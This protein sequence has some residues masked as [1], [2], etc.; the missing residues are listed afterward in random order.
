MS[1]ISRRW[2]N[3][4]LWLGLGALL[5]PIG[6]NCHSRTD[7][8]PAVSQ[9]AEVDSAD[10]TVR[11]MASVEVD[12]APQG[13]SK[14][15]LTPSLNGGSILTAKQA[16]Q[17]GHVLKLSSADDAVIVKGTS[18]LALYDNECRMKVQGHGPSPAGL[19]FE[20]EALVPSNDVAL[21]A[22]T[23]QAEADPCLVRVDENRTLQLIAPVTATDAAAFQA[24]SNQVTAQATVNDP[25]IAEARHIGFSKALESWDWFFS[26]TGITNDVIVAVIDTGIFY[27]HPDLVDNVYT[28]AAG[29]HGYDFVNSD[30]DPL[31]DAGHGT[32]CSGIIGARANNGIGVSGVM[33]MRVKVM[34]VK[35]LSAQGSGSEADI[36]N[37]VR[38]AADQGAQVINLSLGGKFVSPTIRDALVY[39][40]GKGVVLAIAAGNDGVLM[41]AGAN[42]YAPS[43]YA[44]DIPGA[45]A[46]GSVDSINGARS[47]FSNYSTSYVFIGAPGSAAGSNG[48]LSTYL[49]NGY[50][51][52]QG[53]SM[54]SPVVAGAAALLVGA[55]KSHGIAYVPADVVNLLTDSARTN[56]TLTTFFRGGA[57]LDVQR[58]A[59]LFYSRYVMAGNG[60]TEVQ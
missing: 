29:K 56:A 26:G 55:F 19:K 41:D 45:I 14:V 54:A 3:V 50:T 15:R 4:S 16:A 10:Q 49:A 34:G 7:Q 40:A 43:G 44:K 52:L 38:Y 59:Q 13:D 48:V 20:A 5:S 2:R 6:F 8:S 30:D 1:L 46:V 31:D 39:A 22:L 57:T 58:A 25:R 27:T 36:V 42:F 32:H 21:S 28:N 23:A 37:G 35:V 12:G 47:G 18:L 60:G 11:A 51:L 53:T 9:A 33:G 17:A 24:E